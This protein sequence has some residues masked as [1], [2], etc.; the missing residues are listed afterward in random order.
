[1][2]VIHGPV[3]SD[4]PAH[5]ER[6]EVLGT[7]AGWL[8]RAGCVG[9]LLGAR[10]TGKTSACF[11]LR[12]AFGARSRFAYVD[13]QGFQ[14]SSWDE[15]AAYIARSLASQLGAGAS[16]QDAPHI[17]DTGARLPEFLAALAQQVATARI[18]VVFEELGCLVEDSR[19]RLG[20][21]VR[22]VF[23]GRLVE[24]AYERYVF[25]ILGAH[26]LRDVA[27]TRNSPLWNVAEKLYLGDFDRAQVG[28]LL[29]AATSLSGEP[30]Q[31]MGDFL[32]D[33]T[34]GH[35]YWTQRLAREL[36]EHVLPIDPAFADPDAAHQVVEHLLQ[37]EDTNLPHLIELL[38]SE[39]DGL[40][41]VLDRVLDGSLAF[42]RFHRKVAVL[43][44][45]GAIV[46]RGGR[47]WVRNRIYRHVI[48]Q[49]LGRAAPVA[50]APAP[51]RLTPPPVRG[52]TMQRP[53]NPAVFISYTHDSE[54]HRQQVLDLAQ[55]LRADGADCVMD[56]FVNGSPPEGW[57]LW[58]ERQV[59]RADFVLVVCTA[60][61]LR[62]YR[63][64]EQPGKGLGATWEAV[65]ARQELYESSARNT[66]F[67][68]IL[69]PG[70]SQDDIPTPLRPYT[71]H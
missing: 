17:P 70:A 32:Y 6:P 69:F 41:A 40:W 71:W 49:R 60:T 4:S 46:N 7:M 37:H 50:E 29:R 27:G 13:F 51:S 66:K 52:D 10:Q 44:L 42:T 2:F 18:T 38:D 3:R 28:A 55:Q 31:R 48:A 30:A 22:A 53:T 12:D 20:Q 45:C 43:E 47:C 54:A 16:G 11:R 9:V 67:V 63:G 61:Y 15:C 24:P 57:P 14:G 8:E 36:V 39:G 58:M 64:E 23:N 26:E 33:W 56:R 65:L 19:Q 59:Q 5:V 68:P 62:R 25:M 1:M 34:S 35:P 21:M